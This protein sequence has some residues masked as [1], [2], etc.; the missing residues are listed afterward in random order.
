[1]SPAR[2][3][4]SGAV[5]TVL[6]GY[7]VWAVWPYVWTALMSL[8]T[9]EE[10]LRDYYGLPIPAHWDKFAEAWTR[11][12]FGNYLRNSI[13]VTL[14]SIVI[15]TA[16]GSMA[17]YAFGR[18]RYAFRGR[19]PLFGLIFISIMF[20]PQIMLLALFQLLAKYGLINTR[21]GLILTYAGAELP[22]TIYLL[23]AFFAQI[24]AE[25]EDAAR[26]DGCGEWV[27]FSRIMIPIAWPALTTTIILNFILF[28]NEFT[29]A[30][31]L[32]TE[33]KART[34][35]LAVMFLQGETFVDVGML[36]TG[37]MI[38]TIPVIVLY[39]FLSEWFVKGMTMGAV[40]G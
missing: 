27:V 36:A 4:L 33:Q 37:M 6:L 38:S 1:M 29:Y 26:V 18:P 25:I 11:F 16:V 15:V 8:R 35:P 31:V 10:I 9:T 34:L 13:L 3:I 17:A 21:L 14:G 12:G 2:R 28:W 5:L 20:P 19:E 30:V 22:F 39:V 32:I 40:K 23:R 7:T 24:P